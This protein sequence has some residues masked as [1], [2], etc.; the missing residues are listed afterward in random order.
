MKI[1]NPQTPDIYVY[2]QDR[3]ICVQLP[4]LANED[5]KINLSVYAQKNASNI[6]KAQWKEALNYVE[7]EAGKGLSDENYTAEEKQKLE[8]LQN[9]NDAEI[10]RAL[11]KKLTTQTYNEEKVNFV[12][13]SSAPENAEKFI[14]AN[15][16][17]AETSSGI[18]EQNQTIPTGVVRALNVQGRLDVKG[19][20]TQENTDRQFKYVRVQDANGTQ[21]LKDASLWQKHALTEPNGEGLWSKENLN[22]LKK[23]GL[24]YAY[25][26]PETI[27]PKKGLLFNLTSGNRTMQFCFLNTGNDNKGSSIYFRQSYGPWEWDRPRRVLANDDLGYENYGYYNP[28][29]DVIK[30][31]NTG[32]NTHL[33]FGYR[34]R[35]SPQDG[36][37]DFSLNKAGDSGREAIVRFKGETLPAI[38]G[39]FWNNKADFEPGKLCV[40]QFKKIDENII[41]ATIYKP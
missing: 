10:K 26:D 15:G 19:L 5:Q 3:K 36:L 39:V 4:F 34:S 6:E 32:G 7:A 24:Y 1:Y 14:K 20:V 16:T 33:V 37:P 8:S 41:L 11:E 25:Q 18:G 17:Y 21:A 13:K 23:T 9:Y 12:Q 28:E 22:N 30:F 2:E 38:E 35:A 40:I 29:Q 27:F 31:K